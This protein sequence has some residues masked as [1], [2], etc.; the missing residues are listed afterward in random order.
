MKKVIVKTPAKINLTL[1]IVGITGGYHDIYSL[2]CP[3]RVYDEIK[4]AKRKD[5]NIT[6]KEK[7]LLSGCEKENNNAYK[8]AVEFIKKYKTFGADVT[9]KKRI[10]VGG[11]LGGSSADI[12]GTL[13]ALKK[14]YGVKDDV[15]PLANALGSDSGYMVK[16]GAA[17]ISGRGDK[18][19]SAGK[20]P[21]LFLILLT[22]EKQCRSADSYKAFDE[23]GR[24]HD[25][26]TLKA[27]NALKE[28]D[29]TRFFALL[30]NDLTDASATIL[31]DIKINIEKI[32][33]AGADSALMT[34]SGS[35]V[36]GVF[37]DKRARD[38]AYKALKK[39]F[40]NRLIKT[41][42]VS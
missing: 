30:K 17:V 2:V 42:T 36:Y 9:V 18:V 6:L 15:T 37:K 41:E 27:V 14:L 32:K 38:A 16:G 29:L 31:S 25:G 4:V 22:D 39:E 10:P 40:G 20:I 11:G 23:L 3:V 8:A 34:G 1:D 35:C 12:A 7:G 5:G 19:E 28:N 33:A 24:M 21:T 26:A 13:I